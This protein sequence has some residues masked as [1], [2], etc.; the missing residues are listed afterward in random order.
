MSLRFAWIMDG[1]PTPSGVDTVFSHTWSLASDSWPVL[2]KYTAW[3]R[4]I[5]RGPPITKSCLTQYFRR[6][7]ECSTPC[8]VPSCGRVPLRTS[9]CS[10]RRIKL[11][12]VRVSSAV[13]LWPLQHDVVSDQKTRARCLHHR[14]GYMLHASSHCLE[15]QCLHPTCSAQYSPAA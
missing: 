8:S 10:L 11:L 14:R 7:A 13:C 5:G 1:E 6:T 4:V 9:G 15:D 2:G 3:W 12:C